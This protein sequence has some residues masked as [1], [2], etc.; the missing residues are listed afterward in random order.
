MQAEVAL[1]SALLLC[2][3]QTLLAV[4]DRMLARHIF[5]PT[6]TVMLPFTALE[7]TRKL[8]FLSLSATTPRTLPVWPLLPLT[9]PTQEV[10]KDC[11]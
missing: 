9:T 1:M 4:T 11:I 7:Q 6:T 8:H 10:C 2:S 5:L 3:S